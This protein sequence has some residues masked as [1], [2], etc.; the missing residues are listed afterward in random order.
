MIY[1]IR[2]GESF[3]NT[4]DID[5]FDSMLTIK[6]RKQAKELRNSKIPENFEIVYYSPLRRAIETL[7]YSNISSD[8]CDPL[9][10]CRERIC[11]NADCLVLEKFEPESENSF[12]KRMSQL[13]KFLLDKI[14]ASPKLNICVICHG[15]VIMALTNVQPKNTEI[16][17]VTKE[18]LKNVSEGKYYKVPCCNDG[19]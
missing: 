5:T 14:S 3:A 8:V 15:C 13:A 6:G 18:N 12:N 10:L 1:L 16:V 19:W 4:G 9:Y 7:H 2:H 11:T 17:T